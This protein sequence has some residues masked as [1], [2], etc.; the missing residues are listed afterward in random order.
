M[1][2]SPLVVVG[3]VVGVALLYLGSRIRSRARTRPKPA[4]DRSGK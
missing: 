2:E 3:I 1:G 4:E